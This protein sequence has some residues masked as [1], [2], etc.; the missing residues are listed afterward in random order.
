M[1]IFK[2]FTMGSLLN[3]IYENNLIQ[4]NNL[5]GKNTIDS[6]KTK[7][8][9][10]RPNIAL[11]KLHKLHKLEQTIIKNR[12]LKRKQNKIYKSLNNKCISAEGIYNKHTEE[13]YS[14][15]V[16][17]WREVKQT[18]DNHISRRFSWSLGSEGKWKWAEGSAT[19]LATVSKTHLRVSPRDC[20]RKTNINF[21][22]GKFLRILSVDEV[23]SRN[24]G[25]C[26]YEM[27]IE[28]ID[29]C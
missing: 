15:E 13:V 18:S 1:F 6:L 12:S 7:L 22:C 28:S 10:N 25:L 8:N 4:K 26:E 23:K 27:E 24:R 17:F 5:F 20:V 14:Y 29:A 11:H 16:C 9:I 19:K 21:V 2:A 3:T